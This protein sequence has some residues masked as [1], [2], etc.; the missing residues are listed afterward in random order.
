MS[1]IRTATRSDAR[2]LAVIAEQTFR[3]TFAAENRFE[4]MELHCRARY[5]ESAQASEIESPDVT[6][7]LCE[8]DDLLVGFTQLRWHDASPAVSGNAPG[9]IQ[10][11]Y[12]DRPCDDRPSL[13]SLP[14]VLREACRG[15]RSSSPYRRSCR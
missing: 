3:D 4:D 8:E 12:V 1:L 14:A 5:C 10:R 15:A 6:T 7:F 9:E 11:L 13:L 2:A